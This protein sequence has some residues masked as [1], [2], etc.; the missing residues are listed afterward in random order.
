MKKNFCKFWKIIKPVLCLTL[1][2]VLVTML[3]GCNKNR[4]VTKAS[5]GLNNYKI[6]ATL[7]DEEKKITAT[8]EVVFINTIKDNLSFV[9]FNLYGTAFSEDAKI[10]PYT[11]LNSEKCFYD[12]K[13]YGDLVIDSVRVDGQ[14]AN[15][16]IIGED[17]NALKV[18]FFEPLAINKKLSIEIEFILSL[19]KSTHRLG[20]TD[21]TI[22]LGNWYPVL[23]KYENDNFDTSPYYSTGDPFYTDCANYEVSLS[24]PSKYTL[25]S[26]GELVKTETEAQGEMSTT[27]YKALA[28]RDFA[29][30]LADDW[31]MAEE[32][33]SGT[34]VRVY[35]YNNDERLESYL[36]TAVSCFKYF[37]NTFG[38]YP[39]SVLNVV[40]TPFL[41]GGMEY[42][43]L[44]IIADNIIDEINTNKVIIHEIA[45]QWWYSLVG[46]NEL[47]DAWI[48]ES[49]AEYSTLMF[50]EN[51]PEYGVTREQIIKENK[52]DYLLYM[53][54]MQSVVT[55][56]V[57]LSM[58]LYVNEYA[59]E[60]E[61]VYMIYVKGV[62][63][64]DAL[65]EKIGDE[66]YVKGLSLFFKNNKYKIASKTEFIQ[67]FENAS[68]L[69]LEM[70][71]EEWLKGNNII[72]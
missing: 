38:V 1:I 9:C 7:C 17:N 55:S 2:A 64:Q 13:N 43:N 19:A 14:N 8:E 70:F 26:T 36:K 27:E 47:K 34:F 50:F 3:T 54:V 11:I 37:S 51:H 28:V 21:H 67:A 39:Y 33:V 40:F 24:Y 20:Y 5:K 57:N 32:K 62:L 65:R 15:Y 45:H 35:A 4:E 12:G 61:Y 53:D 69:N 16:Q 48:D 49:L 44:V 72:E 58:E 22:S 56:S 31:K 71:I 10:L 23:C 30:C 63:F 42:P 68:G 41:H 46:N 52:E 25:T 18:D 29:M 60:Y 6:T 59:S 66:A